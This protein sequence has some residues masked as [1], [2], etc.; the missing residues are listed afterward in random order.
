MVVCIHNKKNMKKYFGYIRV[1]TVRQSEKG[2]S[3]AEQKIAI[4]A[5]AAKQGLFISEWF[6]ETETAAKVG[7]RL[8]RRMLARLVKG[9]AAGVVIH[10]VDRGA[11][12][13][14]DWA[15]LGSLMDRGIPVHFAHEALDLSSRGGR[16]SADIQAVV[17]ADY[18]RNLRQEV[19]KGMYGRLRQGFFP[20]RA[21]L[22]YCNNGKGMLKTIHPVQGPLVKE[23]FTL[24]A[25]GRYSL[26]DLLAHMTA[27]GLRG[28]HGQRMIVSN[29]SKMLNN[30]FYYGLITVRGETYIGKHEPLI[31]KRLFDECRAVAEGR[32]FVRQP[33]PTRSEFL[34]RRIAHCATCGRALYGERQ[35]GRVY[36][37]CHSGTCKGT[38][39]REDHFRETLQAHLSQLPHRDALNEMLQLHF[40]LDEEKKLQ[41]ESERAKAWTLRTNNALALKERLTDLLIDG[42]LSKESYETRMAEVNNTLLSIETEKNKAKE[43]DGVRQV[44]AKKFLELVNALYILP[45][46]EN[47]ANHRD[48]IRLTISNFT[49]LQKNIEFQWEKPFQ[50]LFEAGGAFCGDANPKPYRKTIQNVTQGDEAR[51]FTKKL[52]DSL[53]DWD[54]VE[55]FAKENHAQN[56][57]CKSSDEAALGHAD[58]GGSGNDHM[59]EYPHIDE[60][61]G[62][63]E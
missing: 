1:S 25:S 45:E 31:S 21:P 17:A 37:R 10:K 40:E 27:K 63:L 41:G 22:G 52:I 36:Y 59:I 29:F 55:V 54:A 42:T 53:M 14:A 20:F 35:K 32:T 16:L 30:P 23:A 2:A 6:E 49:V 57:W 11:R 18:I 33:T 56:A 5:Y 60:R 51:T 19:K 13:L 3:L 44:R 62:A 47:A 24:Y 26:S 34:F 48:I 58:V 38:C 8:F 61:Q 7:R 28:I 9:D 46:T 4:E 50:V 43:G 39:V 15:E 12:N